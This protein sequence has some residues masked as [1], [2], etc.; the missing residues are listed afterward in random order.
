MS[1]K[2]NKDD[3]YW[4]EKLTTDEYR[5]CRE[6]GT[7]R[8]FTGCY[9]D[10]KTKGTYVCKCC[11]MIAAFNDNVHIHYC[12]TCGNRIAFDYVELP[13]ACKL[14]FQELL[15]MNIAPRILT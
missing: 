4:R 1:D 15:T 5:I 8:T 11:G 6:K 13:Y 14:M 3:A 12:R 9:W 10:T 7:E 2:L